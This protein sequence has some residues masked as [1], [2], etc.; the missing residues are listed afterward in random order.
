MYNVIYYFASNAKLEKERR[1]YGSEFNFIF[2]SSEGRLPIDE[3]AI[4]SKCSSSTVTYMEDEKI[5]HSELIHCWNT[6]F[7]PNQLIVSN[8]SRFK[9]IR[10]P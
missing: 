7:Q 5:F 10:R 1:W 2:V 6:E 4:K 9:V 3:I 8:R